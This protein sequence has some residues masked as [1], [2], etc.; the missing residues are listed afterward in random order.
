MSDVTR[1]LRA[2]ESGDVQAASE[3]LPLVCDELRKLNHRRPGTGSRVEET[4]AAFAEAQRPLE[5]AAGRVE[6]R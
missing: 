2:I 6:L 4:H 3:L 1:I 5:M